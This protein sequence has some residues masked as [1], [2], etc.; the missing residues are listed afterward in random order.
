MFEASN[1]WNECEKVE[2]FIYE[3]DS[4]ITVIAMNPD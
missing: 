1:V 4:I 2:L 3:R